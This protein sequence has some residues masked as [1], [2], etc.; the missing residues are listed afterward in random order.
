MMMKPWH[1]SVSVASGSKMI[2]SARVT[3]AMQCPM[4]FLINITMWLLQKKF[5]DSLKAKYMVENATSKKFLASKFF[6]YKMVDSRR[7]VEQFHEIRH[8]LN[9]F[10]KHKMN[11]DESVIVSAIIDKLPPSWKNYKRSF[12]HKK[13]DVTLEELG[14]HL[15]IEE[16]Y[17]INSVDE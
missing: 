13:E 9:Q 15:R 8:I 2:I 4:L 12:K 17:R 6:D 11:M 3:F 10:S 16:E 14:Q 1:R 7:V 5:W